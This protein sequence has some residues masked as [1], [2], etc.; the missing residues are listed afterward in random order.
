MMKVY[1]DTGFFIDYFSSRTMPAILMRTQGRRGRTIHQI[2]QHAQN[3]MY[4]ISKHELF[5]SI[6]SIEEYA[7]LSYEH[8]NQTIKGTYN[9][10]SFIRNIIK[11]ESTKLFNLCIINNIRLIPLDN[12]I[13]NDAITNEGYDK[14]D[15][16]DAI[17]IKTARDAKSD[18]IISTDLHLLSHN[19]IFDG[20]RILDTDEALKLL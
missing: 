4:N 8:L 7:I 18:I 12:T 5:T 2:Q 3:I 15:F 6:I 11:T 13:I 16:H 9:K 10:K 14:L 19:N 17:H 1:F 20:I